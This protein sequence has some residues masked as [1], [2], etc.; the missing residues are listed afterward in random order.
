M[1]PL[2]TH[3]FRLPATFSSLFQYRRQIRF[4][5]V[6]GSKEKSSFITR[7][8]CNYFHIQFQKL[9]RSASVISERNKAIEMNPNISEELLIMYRNFLSQQHNI[10]YASMVAAFSSPGITPASLGTSTSTP[11]ASFSFSLDSEIPKNEIECEV[12]LV[13][14]KN[15]RD[16][17]RALET[18]LNGLRGKKFGY[19]EVIE[20]AS[21]RT[22]YPASPS[23]SLLK[24]S[25][26]LSFNSPAALMPLEKVDASD[27]N[28]NKSERDFNVSSTSS[29]DEGELK[30]DWTDPA[31]N[32]EEAK[33]PK[34]KSVKLE[35]PENDAV[36]ADDDEMICREPCIEIEEQ[37]APVDHA[38][39][40]RIRIDRMR[41]IQ[42]KKPKF[43]IDTVDLTYQSNM[44]RN[45]P[46]SEN[47]SEDQQ[48]R[49]NKNTLAARVSRTKNKAYERMLEKQSLEATAENIDMKR[50]IACLRVYANALL[51]LS[52][53]PKVN[54]SEMWETNIKSVHDSS[55]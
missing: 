35:Q 51:E 17:L 27:S 47:R 9:V 21:A 44:A 45:F 3:R 32:T 50:K 36:D 22:I 42:R 23:T 26:T 10:A 31:V 7:Y 52:G 24:R 1:R 12:E 5:R 20:M 49:R 43:N 18:N 6:K 34:D 28:K 41:K 46:G 29:H 8:N 13:L 48:A 25:R 2:I 38:D 14:V 19:R 16:T 37:E 40:V 15:F 4:E 39:S 11:N 53:L 30:I 54:F 33:H 55:E